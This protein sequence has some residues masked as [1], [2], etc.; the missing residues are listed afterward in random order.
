MS[1][2]VR[3][4]KCRC[5]ILGQV[6]VVERLVIGQVRRDPLLHEIIFRPH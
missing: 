5:L 3:S 1:T 6:A 4:R 2:F